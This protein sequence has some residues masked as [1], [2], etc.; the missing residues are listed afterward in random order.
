MDRT[1]TQARIDAIKWYHEFDFGDGLRAV[2][3][4]DVEGHRTIWEFIERELAAIDFRGKTVLD[5]GCWDGYW[6]FHAER[7]GAKAVLASDDFTQNWSSAGGVYLAKELLRSNVEIDPHRS[8]YDLAGIGRTF[9]V[10]L[11]LGVFY[12]LWDPYHAFAQLRHCCHPGTVVVLEGNVTYGLPPNAVLL[13]ADR[14][15]SRF[16]PGPEG[17][18]GMLSAAYLRP[19]EQVMLHPK[20]QPAAAPPAPE[21]QGRLGWRW[22]LRAAAAAL[23]GSR[24]GVRAAADVLFP[25]APPPPPVPPPKPDSRVFVTCTPFEGV[26]PAHFFRPPFGLHAYDPRF[27][28]DPRRKAA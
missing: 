17:L 14:E 21:P 11:C 8:V 25:P 20:A 26:N 19:S 6:S 9:D 7:R 10:V 18:A 5:V 16:T 27:Q 23:R 4:S 3:T 15:T 13:E 24:A 28:T 22:R 2:T 12:H 1:Q